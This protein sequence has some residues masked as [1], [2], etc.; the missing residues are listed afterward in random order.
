MKCVKCGKELKEGTLNCPN[1]GEKVNKEEHVETSTSKKEVKTKEIK[2][3]NGFALGGV[4]F[5]VFFGGL[6]LIL[7]IMGLIKAKKVGGDGKK[8]AIIG[9][10]ISII[11]LI[12]LMSYNIIKNNL[13][14]NND[15]REKYCQYM[16][17]HKSICVIREDKTYDCLFT[18]CDFDNIQDK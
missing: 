10:A 17:K 4:I 7:S 16:E 9:I 13:L 3:N 11:N 2:E 8:L 12:I 1:C 15:E 14:E 18:N 5:S 6:G